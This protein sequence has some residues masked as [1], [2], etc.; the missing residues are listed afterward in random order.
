MTIAFSAISCLCAY[1]IITKLFYNLEN[2]LYEKC[3]IEALTGARSMGEIMH[4]MIKNNML[5]EADIFDVNYVEIPGSNPPKYHTRY[6]RLFDAWIQNI[7]DQFLSDTDIEFAVLMDKNGYVPTHNSKYSKPQTNNYA[8]DIIYSRSKRKFIV[9]EGIKKIL[10]YRGDDARRVL[11]RRD[12]G[13]T[14]W[15]IG[16]P[17]RLY[18]RQWGSFIIG[19]NLERINTIKNQMLVLIIIALSVILVLTNLIIL[20]IIPRKYLPIR[21]RPGQNN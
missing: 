2:Q 7:E 18:G 20:A 4:F 11:Y 16:T 14:L 15:N 13:E 6:D 5:T 19:V 12:T 1:F 3:R 17:V 21:N 10:N 9:Y 8:R